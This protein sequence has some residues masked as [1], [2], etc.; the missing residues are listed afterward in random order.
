VNLNLNRLLLLVVALREVDRVERKLE[1]IVVFLEVPS[2]TD[3]R[4][5]HHAL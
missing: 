4:F 2:S 1:S 3:K 5:E